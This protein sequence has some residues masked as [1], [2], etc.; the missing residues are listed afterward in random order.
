MFVELD[1]DD[2]K[3]LRLAVDLSRGYQADRRRWPF[4]AVL[5]AGGK[6]LGQGVN[7][8]TVLHDPTAHAEIM[9]LRAAGS[10]LGRHTFEDSVLYTSGEPC[11]MCL[12]AC[13][14]ASIPRIV[15]AATSYDLAECEFHDLAIYT[16]L[17]QSIEH[18]SIRE[19]EAGHELREAA[20]SAVRDWVQR[21]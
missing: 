6:I 18:R 2:E 8:V 5:V 16:E 1:D 21:Q 20:V 7:E 12:A 15:F 10:S 14:W 19:D 3:Y 11:P 17:R 13:Y 9:A 4:G